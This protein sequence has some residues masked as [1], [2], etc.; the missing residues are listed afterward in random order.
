MFL[1][2][3]SKAMHRSE[4]FPK[5]PTVE[6]DAAIDPA[7]ASKALYGEPLWYVVSELFSNSH[8][9]TAQ[10]STSLIYLINGFNF[11][12]N[13]GKYADNAARKSLVEHLIVKQQPKTN[14]EEEFMRLENLRRSIDWL[15]WCCLNTSTIPPDIKKNFSVDGADDHLG[16]TLFD[17]AKARLHG[18]VSENEEESMALITPSPQ[19]DEQV[20]SV[21]QRLH[22]LGN[23]YNTKQPILA[24]YKI[25][26]PQGYHP[27]DPDKI[28]AQMD[29]MIALSEYDTDMPRYSAFAALFDLFG[30]NDQ[31]QKLI[32]SMGAKPV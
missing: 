26:F 4:A 19:I 5:L 14:V 25:V 17:R 7:E 10:A 29:E 30:A 3:G 13:K 27:P 23:F 2:V 9:G 11:F 22:Q 24:V 15:G 8:S 31:L 18:W 21:C 28:P 6:I 1:E 20:N 16:G 32:E 12:N